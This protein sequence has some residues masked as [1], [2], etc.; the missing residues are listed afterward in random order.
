MHM[1]LTDVYCEPWEEIEKAFAI[2]ALDNERDK[3]EVARNEA[4]QSNVK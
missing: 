4:R 2:W 1:S 3:L